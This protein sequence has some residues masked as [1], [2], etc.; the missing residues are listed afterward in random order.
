MRHFQYLSDD[1]CKSIFHV[2]P[3]SWNKDSPKE[4]LANALGGTLYMPGTRTQISN[5]I[6]TGK[7]LNGQYAGLTSMVICLED[8][9]SDDEVESAE[10]NSIVQLQTL[11]TA[12][13]SMQFSQSNL[14]LIFIRVRNPFQIKKLVGD[15][16][17]ASTILS[18]FVLP[19][20]NVDNGKEFLDQ[21]VMVNNTYG[22]SLY[23]LPILETKEVIYRESRMETL[24]SIKKILD[25]YDEIIL[26]IRIGATDFSGLF[27]IRRDCNTVIYDIAVIRDCIADI[28]NFF[29]R[30]DQEY[31]VSGPVWEYFQ[32]SGPNMKHN[33]TNDRNRLEFSFPID[34]EYHE[35]FIQEIL[36]DKSNGMVGKTIIHP[37]H[38]KLVNALN[39]VTHEEYMD[40]LSIMHHFH[41]Q[42]GVIASVFHNKMNEVKPHYHWARK[43]L[44]KSKV[45][46]VL[47]EQQSFIQLLQFNER[48]HL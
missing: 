15:L 17:A 46:G 45:Y 16:G 21:I 36:L 39:A 18:G 44:L 10:I 42:N 30:V 32:S 20:F 35:A 24:L 33:N 48:V 14:P 23:A 19:K 1:Q 2:S 3:E 7:F 38:I 31:V 43:I 27:G 34:N 13:R 4:I 9:I 12:V 22:L 40:S 5:D 47:H 6:L 41:S 11:Y 25:L 29:G 26:N 37:S 8:S 28:M